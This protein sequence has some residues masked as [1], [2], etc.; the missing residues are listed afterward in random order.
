MNDR[1]AYI[2]DINWVNNK[3]DNLPFSLIY[4]STQTD[5]TITVSLPKPISQ[6]KSL[7]V[8]QDVHT[9]QYDACSPSCTISN[10]DLAMGYR[11]K[12]PFVCSI[13]LSIAYPYIYCLTLSNSYADITTVSITDTTSITIDIG[14][15]VSTTSVNRLVYGN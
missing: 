7:F 8:I 6:F 15:Y 5:R 3:V 10:I 11:Y 14:T 1:F 9:T 4:Q 12:P 2:S 13:Y